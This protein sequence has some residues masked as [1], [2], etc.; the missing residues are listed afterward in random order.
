MGEAY[1]KIAITIMTGALSLAMFGCESE[2][3][4]TNT[5]VAQESKE[6]QIDPLVEKQMKENEKNGNAVGNSSNKG[7]MAESN[8]WIYYAVNGDKNTK[9]LAWCFFMTLIFSHVLIIKE[10]QLQ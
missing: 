8:G 4:A 3:K 5:N 6:E 2:K 10:R 7:K 1:K 9:H